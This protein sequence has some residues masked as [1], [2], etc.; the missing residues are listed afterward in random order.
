M[1]RQRS[2]GAGEAG[3]L[4]CG[5]GCPFSWFLGVNGLKLGRVIGYL[6]CLASEGLPAGSRWVERQ[7]QCWLWAEVGEPC[8]GGGLLA[9]SVPHQLFVGAQGVAPGQLTWP[10]Q[11]GHVTFPF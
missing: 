9:Q 2:E 4:Y 11:P 3:S 6:R 7:H 1:P 10:G 5:Q 8:L